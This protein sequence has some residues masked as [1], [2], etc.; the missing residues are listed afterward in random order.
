MTPDEMTSDETGE[1]K[2]ETRELIGDIPE[3]ELVRRHV[4][5]SQAF[6]RRMLQEQD[7]RCRAQMAKIKAQV[8]T[9]LQQFPPVK[10]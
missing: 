9:Y 8:A 6:Q 7:E 5:R 3:R 4:E 10:H 1:M 2:P